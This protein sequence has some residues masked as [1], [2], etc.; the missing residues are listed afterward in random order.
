MENEKKPKVAIATHA[1]EN[2]DFDVH[3]NHLYAIAHWVSKYEIHFIGRRGMLAA[4]ARNLIVE[5]AIERKCEH[6]FI[7][8]A[9]HLITE[10]T[11][12]LLME[13]KEEAIVSG[14]VCKRL[15]PYPQVVWLKDKDGMYVEFPLPL[16]G[17]LAEVAIGPFGCTLINMKKLQELE[18]P[19]FR[20]TCRKTS[21]GELKNFRSDVNLSNAFREKGHKVWVDTRVL[22]GHLGGKKVIFPQNAGYYAATDEIADELVKLREGM[23]GDHAGMEGIQR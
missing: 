22:V 10:N 2:V 11:L 3:F 13:N 5:Q 19:Y 6:L 9:D 16:D 7:L 21:T 8:D 4:D 17:C 23:S 20:D 14:L 1:F 15:H 12:P 18:P